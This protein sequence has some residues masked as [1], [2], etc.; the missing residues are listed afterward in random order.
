[1][2]AVRLLADDLTGAL[3]TA[4]ELT[5]LAGPLPVHW[6][7][8]LPP[9]LPASCAVDT[10]T[11]EKDWHVANAAVARLAPDLADAGL[12]FKKVDSLL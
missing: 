7:S 4:A 10:G 3:D 1:M 2:T 8:A 11:R 6:A 5:P 12:S 9:V